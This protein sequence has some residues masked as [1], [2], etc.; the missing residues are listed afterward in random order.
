MTNDRKAIFLDIDGTLSYHSAPPCQADIDALRRV[1]AAGHAVFVNTG[2]ARGFL[3]DNLR[4]ADY[5]DGFLCGCGTQ[6][7]LHGQSLFSAEIARPLLREVAAYYLARPGRRCLFEGE[8]SLYIVGGDYKGVAW[9]QVTRAD[10]FE[11]VYAHARITK[12]TVLG[13]RTEEERA[14]FAGRLDTVLQ[15]AADWY[16][17]VLPGCNK[18][19]GLLRACERLGVLPENSIAIGDSENDLDMFACAGIAVAMQNASAA[20]L[21]AADYVTGACGEGGVAQ[22]VRALVLGEGVLERRR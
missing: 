6:M 7:L 4:D 19:R 2:R 8:D 18:G 11:T 12:L 13:T 15:S 1:R 10:D 20:A 9:P 14:L 22:A 16:E 17:A 5:L 3:P 21:A